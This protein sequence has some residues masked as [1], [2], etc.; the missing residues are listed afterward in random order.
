M[1][2]PFEVGRDWVGPVYLLEV[3]GR[4]GLTLARFHE[5]G[6]LIDLVGVEGIDK[7]VVRLRLEPEVLERLWQCWQRWREERER[8][9]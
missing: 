2:L 3:R 4:L 5:D 7:E 8:G 1:D 9:G 6:D